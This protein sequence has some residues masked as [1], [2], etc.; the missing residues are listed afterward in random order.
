LSSQ[1]GGAVNPGVGGAV[2]FSCRIEA[3]AVS[4]R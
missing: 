3:S 2:C 1:I 4:L